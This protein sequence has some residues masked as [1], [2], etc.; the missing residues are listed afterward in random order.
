MAAFAS[1]VIRSVSSFL[2]FPTRSS[3]RSR[4]SR[5]V[6]GTASE[7]GAC[8]TIKCRLVVPTMAGLDLFK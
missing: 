8:Q 6:A 3:R 5:R 7:V 1:V 4:L 2:H